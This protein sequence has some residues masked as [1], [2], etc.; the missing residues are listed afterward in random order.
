[1]FFVWKWVYSFFLFKFSLLEYNNSDAY[2]HIHILLYNQLSKYFHLFGQVVFYLK[3]ILS[4]FTLNVMF[5]LRLCSENF[6]PKV[7]IFYMF[8]IFNLR[9]F[10][11][12]FQRFGGLKWTV[13]TDKWNWKETFKMFFWVWQHFNLNFKKKFYF[14]IKYFDC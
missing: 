5:H 3:R 10:F 13:K 9:F 2:S 8:Y 4:R 11:L 7:L 14:R 1:M 6:Y 12:L